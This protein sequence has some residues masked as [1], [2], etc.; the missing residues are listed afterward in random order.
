[1][2]ARCAPVGPNA[3]SL[4]RPAD[5]PARRAQSNENLAPSTIATIMKELR[6]LSNEP[7]DGI[8]VVL[9]EDDVTDVSAEITGPG[10]YTTPHA[11]RQ[12]RARHRHRKKSRSPCSA[13]FAPRCLRAHTIRERRVQGQ[14]GAS[15]GLPSRAA[16]G[17][18][19]PLPARPALASA[20][21]ARSFFLLNSQPP[22][23]LLLGCSLASASPRVA[24]YFL[25]RIYHPNISKAG[26]ICVNTLKKD[27][28]SS[29]G[30]GHVLQVV[31]CLLI[32]PFPES[33]LNEEAGKDFM[34]DYEEYSK[35]AKMYTEVH[36]RP[37]KKSDSGGGEDA[38]EV[39]TARTHA[40]ARPC[41]RLAWPAAA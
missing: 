23:W 33:A 34:E 32:N 31:R 26:E 1:M 40:R 4:S 10:A 13:P 39:G 11:P 3:V 24:G 6:K 38:A 28:Q 12:P 16:K 20:P 9:N 30:I 15:I 27:W 8:K 25:T 22:L 19:P 17:C 35:K 36:A 7:L 2:P 5:L 14:A 37:S 21:A 41:A 29:L 18:A